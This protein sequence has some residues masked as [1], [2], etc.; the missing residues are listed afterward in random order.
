MIKEN[1]QQDRTI[2]NNIHALFFVLI[3]PPVSPQRTN[4]EK[5]TRISIGFKLSTNK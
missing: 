5:L 3:L 4:A 2:N 1:L